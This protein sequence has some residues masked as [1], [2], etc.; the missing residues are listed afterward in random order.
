MSYFFPV[1]YKGFPQKLMA[2]AMKEFRFGCC[3]QREAVALEFR[4]C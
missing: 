4:H 1:A 2:W 3:V